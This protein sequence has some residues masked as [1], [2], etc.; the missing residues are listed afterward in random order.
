MKVKVI[1]EYGL[2]EALL[3][4]GLNFGLTSDMSLDDIKNNKDEVQD[5]LFLVAKK[6]SPMENAHNKFL[7]QI[8][9]W[10]DIKAPTYWW[11]QMD[12]YRIGVT[13]S[14]ESKM[15]SLTKRP[16]IPE[17][18]SIQNLSGYRNIITQSFPEIDEDAEEWVK[19]A[20]YNDVFVS[21]QGRVKR[22]AWSKRTLDGKTRYFKERIYINTVNNFGYAHIT[23]RPD[24]GKPKIHNVH[25]LVADAFIPN[26]ENKPQVN[27]INGNKLDNRV[28]N[29][30]WVTAKE[31]TQKAMAEGIKPKNYAC[32]QG[33]FTQ[34]ER[35]DI[36]RRWENGETQA[37][38]AKSLGVYSSRINSIVRGKYLYRQHFNEFQ[39]FKKTFIDPLN[40]LRDEY[41]ETKNKALWDSILRLLPISYNQRRIV[42][43]NYQTLRTILKQRKGHKLG[44]WAIFRKAVMEGVR[45]PEFL[46]GID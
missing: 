33:K 5:R 3:G 28:E 1:S 35:E 19:V 27:H 22:L 2:D 24:N 25:R 8:G 32:Y 23:I 6:L 38:I 11:L 40:E 14:S 9:V 18:F 36:I 46:A 16:F 34:E 4:L 43:C 45:Y 29:L 7:R 44:E 12:Q 31:N 17:D 26:P 10:L 15:H 37:E 20:Q 30:E 39:Q 41:L 21:N 13:S 42:S